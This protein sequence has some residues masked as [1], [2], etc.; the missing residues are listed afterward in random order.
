[1]DTLNPPHVTAVSIPSNF[2]STDPSLASISNIFGVHLTLLSAFLPSSLQSVSSTTSFAY[3][4][5]TFIFDVRQLLISL[6]PS[7]AGLS[8]GA[9]GVFYGVKIDERRVLTLSALLVIFNNDG[10]HE[11]A[12]STLS[13]VFIISTASQVPRRLGPRISEGVTRQIV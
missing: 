8:Y 12:F 4:P 10:G 5:H 13:A 11:N 2:G 6:Q 9:D 3:Q 1:M 7:Y